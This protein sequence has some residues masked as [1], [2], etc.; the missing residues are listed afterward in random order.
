MQVLWA[1]LCKKKNISEKDTD[2]TFRLSQENINEIESTF[3]SSR[4]EMCSD[5][6][7]RLKSS[8]RME[9]SRA[10]MQQNENMVEDG[11]EA[12]N[13][14]GH[15]VLRYGND[16]DAEFVCNLLHTPTTIYPS[17]ST[18]TNSTN[19]PSSSTCQRSNDDSQPETLICRRSPRTN[20]QSSSENLQLSS[21]KFTNIDH[22]SKQKQSS[23]RKKQS[24]KNAVFMKQ[25]SETEKM[26][27][28]S[29]KKKLL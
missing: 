8:V 28:F 4:F 29:C 12:E 11:G 15:F 27:E 24:S 20:N 10:Q 9:P 26:L 25:W 21:L 22:S 2:Y 1:L 7:K 19:S 3:G 17:P 5:F 14:N 16:S 23:T 6:S 18:T 13:N